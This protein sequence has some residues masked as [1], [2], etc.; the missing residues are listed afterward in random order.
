MRTMFAL[1]LF[2]AVDEARRSVGNPSQESQLP[3]ESC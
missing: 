2:D 3:K 1:S